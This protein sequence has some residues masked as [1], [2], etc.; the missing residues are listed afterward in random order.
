MKKEDEWKIAFKNKHG[1]YEWLVMSFGLTN[2]PRTFIRLMNHVLHAFIDKFM[3][4]YFDNTL[5]YNKNLNEHL[6]HLCSVFSVLRDEKLYVNLKKC[7]IYME[8]IMFIGYVVTAHSIKMDENKVKV[9]Q[10]WPTPKFMIEVRSF[11]GLANFYKRFVKD[12]STLAAPPLIE[13]VKKSIGFKWGI[14]QDNAFNLLKEKLCLTPLLALLD[15]TKAFK[16]ECDALEIGIGVGLIQ[17]K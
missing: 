6:D 2:S 13:I 11:H 14:E 17:Y 5:I 16:I 4:M 3:V 8:K 12:F 15:F 1:L 10:D 7:T 9:I